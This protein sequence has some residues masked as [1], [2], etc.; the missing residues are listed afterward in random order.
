MADGDLLVLPEADGLPHRLG[1][2]VNH[3][4]QNRRFLAFGAPVTAIKTK[5]HRLYGDPLN[6]GNLG[7]CVPSAGLGALNTVPLR[8][9][10]KVWRSADITRFYRLVTA[11]DPFPGQ[12]EPDDTGSDGGSMGKVLRSLS[13]ISEWRWCFG[14]E[15]TRQ[16][17]MVSALMTGIG[18]TESMFYPDARG[19][20]SITGGDVGGHEFVLRGY[21]LPAD[22]WLCLNSWGLWGL[23][24]HFILTGPQLRERLEAGGDVTQLVR[25]A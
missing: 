9:L 16:A 24:G 25:A 13:L 23:R 12:Y 4:P 14:Y 5:T 2:N 19:R 6:Q 10:G 15:A 20:V 7:Q 17:I 11:T 8:T 3:D 1:R 21:N 18:W 22:E